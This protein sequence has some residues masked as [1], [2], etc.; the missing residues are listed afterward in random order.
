MKNDAPVLYSLSPDRFLFENYEPDYSRL[1]L[2]FNLVPCD[3]KSGEEELVR[4]LKEKAIGFCRAE[5]LPVRPKKDMFAIMC[6]D[7]DGKFWFHVGKNILDKFK[8]GSS[9]PEARR[10]QFMKPFLNALKTVQ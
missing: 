7:E 3:F 2:S 1:Q 5:S 4:A 8:I 10:T 6:E 9:Y